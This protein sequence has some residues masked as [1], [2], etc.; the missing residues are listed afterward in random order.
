MDAIE[1]ERWPAGTMTEADVLRFGL[2]CKAAFYPPG[3]PALTAEDEAEAVAEN[4]AC[5]RDGVPMDMPEAVMHA[6][7]VGGRLAAVGTTFV[8]TVFLEIGSGRAIGDAGWRAMEVL[9][10]G[11][12][13]TDAA[14]QGRGLGTALLRDAFA[15]IDELGL[16]VSLFQTETAQGLY[17]RLGARA[18]SNRF[19]DRTADDPQ[20]HPWC[21]PVVMTYPAAA[22][23]PAGRIDLNGGCY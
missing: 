8:R 21:D 2:L 18:V 6:V 9:A 11:D 10:L 15:R 19:V 23:W 7:R 22:A 16:K 4:L 17:E 14:W 3:G 1:V 5:W 12:V 20:R 13:A